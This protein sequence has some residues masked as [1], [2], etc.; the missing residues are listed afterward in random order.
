M[1]IA[2]FLVKYGLPLIIFTLLILII[3]S[4]IMIKLMMNKN[5]FDYITEKLLHLS[6][7]EIVELVKTDDSLFDKNV[8]EN[9]IQNDDNQNNL[10]SSLSTTSL[11]VNETD[12]NYNTKSDRKAF[13]NFQCYYIKI[14]PCSIFIQFP[15]LTRFLSY[16]LFWGY[17]SIQTFC[18]EEV[19]SDSIL[20]GYKCFNVSIKLT[21]KLYR[22]LFDNYLQ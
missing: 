22:Y 16:I 20:D 7:W 8:K 4:V 5:Y 19:F 12:C 17:F 6:D 18:L 10:P 21:G 13:I 9:I 1:E 3:I 11:I 14:D 2:E 15:Y